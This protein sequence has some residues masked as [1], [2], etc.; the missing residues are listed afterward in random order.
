MNKTKKILALILALTMLV[1]MGGC[2]SKPQTT[3]DDATDAQGTDYSDMKIGIMSNTTAQD[4]GWGSALYESVQKVKADLKLTDEQVIWVES[5]YDGTADVDNMIDQL[6]SEGC[7]VIMAHSAGYV[8]QLAAAAKKYPDV[9][10]CGYECPVEGAENYAMYSINDQ[11]ASFIC[12]YV[13]ARM[14][15]GDQLGYIGN[16]PTSDLICCLDSFALGA[17]YA[18]ASAKVQVIWINSWYDPATEKQAANTLLESGINSVGYMGSTASVA[19]ACSEHGA[20]TTGMYIDMYEFGKDSVLTSHV[21]DWSLII[22]DI[23]NRVAMGTW[24]TD[25]IIY[26]FTDGAARVADFNKDIIPEDVIKDAQDLKA[27][28]MSGEVKVFAGEISDNKGNV[29][30]E[31]GK[32]LSNKDLIYIDFLVDNVIGDIP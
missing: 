15:K 21:F 14:S 8:D 31:E 19:Q 17:K 28:L 27:K 3:P 24:S 1:C 16:M 4:G 23:I 10:F 12:G 26:G 11:A 20:F 13:A 2:A 18:N 7:K 5:I 25:P 32:E 9:Y 6:V 29:V 30:V 22:T